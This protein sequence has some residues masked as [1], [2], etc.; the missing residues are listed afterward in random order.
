MFELIVALALIPLALVGLVFLVEILFLVVVWL[1]CGGWFIWDRWGLWGL[2]WLI[3]L[4][5]LIYD[6]S[7][8]LGLLTLAIFIYIYNKFLNFIQRFFQ[9]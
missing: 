2:A 1:I 7:V 6:S 8:G 3:I 4:V 9:A 5:S